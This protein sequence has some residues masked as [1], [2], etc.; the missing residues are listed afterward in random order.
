MRVFN[1][2]FNSPLNNN[3]DPKTETRTR[4]EL[5]SR[6][7]R[8]VY[9]GGGGKPFDCATNKN[10][11]QIVQK[12]FDNMNKNFSKGAV[13]K[14]PNLK[15]QEVMRQDGAKAS[16]YRRGI[17]KNYQLS[18]LVQQDGWTDEKYR[19][20]TDINITRFQRAMKFG[21]PCKAY[22]FYKKIKTGLKRG[23]PEDYYYSKIYEYGGTGDEDLLERFMKRN[24]NLLTTITEQRQITDGVKQNLPGYLKQWEDNAEGVRSKYKTY[25]DYVVAAEQWKKD[26][27]G[28]NKEKGGSTTPWIETN[29]TTEK[30]NR[31]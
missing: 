11:A 18:G 21:N 22:E 7:V 23:R 14:N 12:A 2:P 4:T 5:S 15:W 13:Y 9:R 24:Q 1:T 26:N 27:P 31:T 30:V 19:K 3:G 17:T 16:D 28:W 25:E 6:G 20:S 29:R 8:D 10:A